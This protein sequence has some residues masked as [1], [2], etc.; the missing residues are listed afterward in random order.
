MESI[1]GE[2]D[3]EKYDVYNIQI[4]VR[5]SDTFDNTKEGQ[6]DEH[7]QALDIVSDLRRSIKYSY[8]FENKKI[9]K[10]II[11]HD[12]KENEDGVGCH[13]IELEYYL[14]IDKE[15]MEDFSTEELHDILDEEWNGGNAGCEI[16]I[17]LYER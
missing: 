12:E 2:V 16:V 17:T 9:I 5:E 11:A 1:L 14:L 4:N 10:S 7:G 3:F 6:V 8:P 15:E 13:D